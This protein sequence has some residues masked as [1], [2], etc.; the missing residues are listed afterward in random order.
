MD[1]TGSNLTGSPLGATPFASLDSGQSPISSFLN[2]ALT[3]YTQIRTADIT[4][5]AAAPDQAV[6]PATSPTQVAQSLTGRN[7]LLL[8]VGGV[9]L[10]V[11]VLLIARK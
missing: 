8:G 1:E 6:V 7:M 10:I 5:R 2:N 9:A 11:V 3:A 4:A